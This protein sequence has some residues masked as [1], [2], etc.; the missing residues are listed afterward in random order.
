[1]KDDDRLWCALQ[2]LLTEASLVL[3]V[4]EHGEA[5]L[6]QHEIGRQDGLMA[7][8]EGGADEALATM[9]DKAQ[10]SRVGMDH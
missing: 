6:Q 2:G 5:L 10:A 9:L 3:A 7:D 8:D 4:K 1:M